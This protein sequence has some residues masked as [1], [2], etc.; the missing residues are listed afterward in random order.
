MKHLAIAGLLSLVLVGKLPAQT[1]I[2]PAAPLDSGRAILRDAIVVLRDS[3]GAIE[4]AAARLQRDYRAASGAA[5][6]ARARLMRDA[7]ASSLRTVAPT[8]KVVGSAELTEQKRLVRQRELVTALDT[9]KTALSL[10]QT[11]FAAMSRPDQGERV[12]DYGND[13]AARVQRALR[14]YER[15]LQGFLQVMGIRVVPLGLSRT[16]SAG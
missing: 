15:T 5:L 12:R 1:V 14:R 3:L 2:H 9:L 6:V 10:C 11:E 13:R 4:G 8:R 7:C 16:P